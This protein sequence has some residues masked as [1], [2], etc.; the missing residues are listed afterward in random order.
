MIRVLLA[1]DETL[2]RRS[3][4]A[5][6]ELSDEL[7]V[8]AQASDGQEAVELTREH[9]PDVV[10]LDLEMPRLDGVDAATAILA[11]RPEQT[12]VLLTR[13][14]RPGVLVRALK[15][16]V[17]GFAL[18]SIDPEELERVILQV[19]SGRRWID[20]ELSASAMMDDCPLTDRELETLRLTTEGMTVREM[21][22]RLHLASGT[23]RNYLSSAMQKT[24][25]SSRH[26]AARIARERDWL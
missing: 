8:V 18:K 17:R 15:A 1:D 21:S 24:G 25:A 4:A 22:A 11:E 10:L 16:G 26:E 14:G 7:T 2:L 23:V 12:I 9:D 3:I 19:H 13:H 5:L 20:A 6:L